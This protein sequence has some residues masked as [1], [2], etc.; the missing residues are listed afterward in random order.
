MPQVLQLW[1]HKQNK[2]IKIANSTLEWQRINKHD[3]FYCMFKNSPYINQIL[4]QADI[5]SGAAYK[6]LGMSP[7][8]GLEKNTT[9][10]ADEEFQPYSVLTL[11]M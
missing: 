5:Y 2:D 10:L 7:V 1:L 3:D 6:H 8:T 9:D 11:S 4:R